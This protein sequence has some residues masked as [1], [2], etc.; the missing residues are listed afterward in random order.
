MRTLS[1]YRIE[2]ANEAI[3]AITNGGRFN[4]TVYA[5]AGKKGYFVSV[6]VSNQEYCFGQV[7]KQDV[8]AVKA[9][10]I[11]ALSEQNNDKTS[12]KDERFV[13]GTDAWL[14]SGMNAE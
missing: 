8:E 7:D 3:T 14:H 5:K 10:F 11:A 2:R 13:F 6:Y 9:E 4:G 12:S 1:N